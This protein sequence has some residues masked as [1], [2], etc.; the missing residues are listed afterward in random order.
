MTS[1]GRSGATGWGGR[2]PRS[3]NGVSTCRPRSSARETKRKPPS[4]SA[5]TT[6]A[7]RSGKASSPT[8]PRPW[9]PSGFRPRACRA[10]R[11]ARPA[12][13]AQK[14]ERTDEGPAIAEGA[15]D[16]RAAR[17]GGP[18]AG[19]VPGGAGA[20]GAAASPGGPAGR[21]GPGAQ[22]DA[23]RLRAPGAAAGLERRV[24]PPP[25]AE[26][27]DVDFQGGLAVPR[28]ART[29][30]GELCLTV[31]RG[32]RTVVLHLTYPSLEALWFELT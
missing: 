14:G 2:W 31:N 11:A 29:E 30:S 28:L 12:R 6:P 20:G 16:R 21:G 23:D 18:P 4:R 26:R 17:T 7:S 10:P 9:T 32:P 22:G 19:R 25:M 8:T 5:S 13:R 24:G 3:P 15:K 27:I 1:R